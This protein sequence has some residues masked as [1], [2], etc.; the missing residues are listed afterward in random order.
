MESI[1]KPL[2]G[3]EWLISMSCTTFEEATLLQKEGFISVPKPK[4][5]M[6]RNENPIIQGPS[7]VYPSATRLTE[8]QTGSHEL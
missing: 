8:Q 7:S 3:N 6:D 2:W 5:E 4:S 1:S